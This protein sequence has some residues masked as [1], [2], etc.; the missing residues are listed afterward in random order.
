MMDKK[1]LDSTMYEFSVDQEIRNL[2]L[3][4]TVHK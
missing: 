3:D 1:K 2:K 4:A